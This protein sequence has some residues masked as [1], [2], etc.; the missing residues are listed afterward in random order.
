MKFD[1]IRRRE[2]V[3]KEYGEPVGREIFSDLL[4]IYGERFGELSIYS[5]FS[6]T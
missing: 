3:D 5:T 2:V 4:R 1:V 6:G